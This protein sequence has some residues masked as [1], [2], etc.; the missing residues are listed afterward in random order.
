[1]SARFLLDSNVISDYGNN[2]PWAGKILQKISLYGLHRCHVSAVTWHELTF[3]LGALGGKR[4]M[5]FL[6]SITK[7]VLILS[8]SVS[9]SPRSV[10]AGTALHVNAI[11]EPLAS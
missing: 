3:G 7:P 1:M 8:F 2:K 11:N 10:I 6:I 4:R 9:G 5:A